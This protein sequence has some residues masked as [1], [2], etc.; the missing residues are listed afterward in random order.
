MG[1]TRAYNRF[2]ISDTHFFHAGVIQYC[3]RPYKTVA[4][5]HEKMI[6]VWNSTVMPNDIVYV[7]GDFGF[8]N[9]QDGKSVL[10][11]LNGRKILVLGNHDKDGLEKFEKMGF[12]TVVNELTITLFKKKIKLCHYPYFTWKDWFRMHILNQKIT[13]FDRRPAR[14]DEDWLIH[15]HVHNN[16]PKYNAGKKMINVSWDAWGRPVSQDEICSIMAKE[17][18]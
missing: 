2:F 11:K 13:C 7:V 10:D 3:N 18:K 16:W 17:S 1:H 5:M 14:T 4:E 9:I 6:K 12:E 8:C 15:G